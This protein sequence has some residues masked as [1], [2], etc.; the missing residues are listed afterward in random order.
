MSKQLNPNTILFQA[1]SQL[2]VQHAGLSDTNEHH[3]SLCFS[4][5]QLKYAMNEYTI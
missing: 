2:S 5:I 4:R 3:S 1:T